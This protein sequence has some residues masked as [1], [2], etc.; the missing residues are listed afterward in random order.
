MS[1]KRKCPLRPRRGAPLRRD[2][3]DPRP[4]QV[5]RATGPSAG[6]EARCP[7]APDPGNCSQP[8]AWT[9]FSR[10]ELQRQGGWPG[11]GTSNQQV[12]FRTRE[13]K[14]WGALEKGSTSARPENPAWQLQA[15]VRRLPGLLHRPCVRAPWE[16]QG[17]P[18]RA[19]SPNGGQRRRDTSK[20]HVPNLSGT[21]N[22]F[23]GRQCFHP[24][25]EGAR[26]RDDSSAPH[27]LS[28]LNGRQRSGHNASH[29]ERL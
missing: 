23:C 5:S 3:A 26:F 17:Q 16:K 4:L 15:H 12:A 19:E 1:K 2:L 29:G 18:Q 7:R 8:R 6:L 11:W 20:S 14:A 22:W 28:S 13:Q 27:L 25:R 10:E 9:A 24:R 21:R